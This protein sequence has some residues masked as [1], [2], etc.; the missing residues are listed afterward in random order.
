MATDEKMIT[1][2]MT[3]Y[4][5]GKVFKPQ[6]QYCY[7]EKV[8]ILVGCGCGG[9]AKE[10]ILHYRVVLDGGIQYDIPADRVVESDV[11]IPCDDRDFLNA[12]AN[13]GDTNRV[14]DF[15]PYRNNLDPNAIAASANNVPM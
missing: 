3:T 4:V 1:I 7:T 9:K 12:R 10:S 11:V 15:N 13:I 8:N 14:S 6:E 2:V 5:K